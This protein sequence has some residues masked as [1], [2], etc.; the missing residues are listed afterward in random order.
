MHTHGTSLHPD[1]ATKRRLPSQ[2]AQGEGHRSVSSVDGHAHT[3]TRTPMVK[4]TSTKP[5][6]TLSTLIEID[7]I[8]S[9]LSGHFNHAELWSIRFVSQA[10]YQRVAFTIDQRRRRRSNR[11]TTTTTTTTATC[12]SFRLDLSHVHGLSDDRLLTSIAARC[13]VG[14][15]EELYLDSCW[16]ITNV[17]IIRIVHNRGV[18]LRRVSLARIYS[19]DDSV[20]EALGRW[21]GGRLE[22]LDL[23]DCW[24]VTSGGLR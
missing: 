6:P 17:T 18:N 19:I 7:V 22:W 11:T 9:Q 1:K 16:N 21:V 15:L 10:F 5:R 20:L 4:P 12:P 24:R 13:A 8:W 23:E 3:R 14:N 2:L